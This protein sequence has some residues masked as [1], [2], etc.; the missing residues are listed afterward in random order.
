MEF[1]VTRYLLGI[2]ACEREGAKQDWAEGEV[3]LQCR[4]KKPSR[5]WQGALERLVLLPADTARPLQPT[6][7]SHWMQAAPQGHDLGLSQC[8]A[9]AELKE[10]TAEAVHLCVHHSRHL[11]LQRI[12]SI[13]IYLSKCTLHAYFLLS[14]MMNHLIVFLKTEMH[15]YSLSYSLSIT[16]GHDGLYT[17]AIS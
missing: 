15:S 17:V 11:T 16:F 5:P 3:K 13:S 9:D 4:L 6:Q 14:Q 7:L 8:A 1:G 10:L 12:L 2:N